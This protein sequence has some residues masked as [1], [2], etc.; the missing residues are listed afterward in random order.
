MQ[1]NTVAA[2]EVLFLGDF[3]D[4]PREVEF[5]VPFIPERSIE[6][7]F[8]DRRRCADIRGSEPVPSQHLVRE[9]DG[10]RFHFGVL[11]QA[12]LTPGTQRICGFTDVKGQVVVHSVGGNERDHTRKCYWWR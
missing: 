2:G 12:V 1:S 6:V 4:V 5:L 7:A 8:A 3:M 11:L 10:D 9:L